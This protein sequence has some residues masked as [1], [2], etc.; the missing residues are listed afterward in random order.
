MRVINLPVIVALQ[1]HNYHTKL[2]EASPHATYSQSTVQRVGEYWSVQNWSLNQ[3]VHYIR[4]H[5]QPLGG[6]GDVYLW[7]RQFSHRAVWKTHLQT[8]KIV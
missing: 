1:D 7:T 4:C 2:H 6:E 8:I 5:A 3:C